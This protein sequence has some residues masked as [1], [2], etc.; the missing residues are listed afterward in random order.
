MNFFSEWK[1]RIDWPPKRVSLQEFR[2]R[3]VEAASQTGAPPLVGVVVFK[4]EPGEREPLESRSFLTDSAQPAFE[5]GSRSDEIAGWALD[6][7]NHFIAIGNYITG[8]WD[9]GGDPDKWEVSYC[10][11]PTIRGIGV[12]SS[13]ELPRWLMSHGVEDNPWFGETPEG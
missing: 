7:G 12:R 6:C 4:S 3:M 13:D 8:V 10:Y 2:R 9:D 5:E 1:S 11:F